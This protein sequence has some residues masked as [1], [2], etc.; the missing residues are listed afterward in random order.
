MRSGRDGQARTATFTT[1]AAF[2]IGC[3]G[4]NRT[5]FLVVMSHPSY[6]CST[7]L[8][9]VWKAPAGRGIVIPASSASDGFVSRPGRPLAFPICFAFRRIFGR[10]IAGHNSSS[11]PPLVRP[12]RGIFGSADR[13]RQTQLSAL[14]GAPLRGMLWKIAGPLVYVRLTR[15]LLTRRSTAHHLPNSAS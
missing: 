4:W 5:I 13:R 11:R 2:P 7:L 10:P 8:N 15:L 3:R 6:Q 1:C 14:P 12:S 9:G